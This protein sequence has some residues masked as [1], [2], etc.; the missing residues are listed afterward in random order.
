MN[1]PNLLFSFHG[2]INRAK[3]WIAVAL[4]LAATVVILV[5]ALVPL[6]GLFIAAIGYVAMLIS[7]VA[8][9]IKRLHDRAKSGWWLLLFYGVPLLLGVIQTAANQTMDESPDGLNLVVSLVNGAI[10]IWAL[11]ELGCLRG[12]IGS[13]PYG[14]DPLA[15]APRPVTSA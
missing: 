12:T 7:G 10:G 11:V 6:L 13:N 8:V 1:F 5:V 3:Y 2:R 9:G 14:P 4:Y 15:T